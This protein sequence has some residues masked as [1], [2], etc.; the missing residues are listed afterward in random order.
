MD[1]LDLRRRDI[2]REGVELASRDSAMHGQN[3]EQQR[4]RRILAGHRFR[5]RG[6]AD[7]ESQLI[8]PFDVT[9][10]SPSA[11][12]PLLAYDCATNTTRALDWRPNHWIGA[13]R[14]AR[15]QND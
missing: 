7:V 4:Q 3:V 13:S 9:L 15:I 11:S 10:L 12:G 8:L 6:I 5:R 2:V 14:F 1:P